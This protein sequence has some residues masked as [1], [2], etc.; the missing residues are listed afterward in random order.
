MAYVAHPDDAVGRVL[1]DDV[2]ELLRRRKPADGVDGDLEGLRSCIRRLPKLP[3]WHLDVLLL[4]GRDHV[5]GSKLPSCQAHRVH[6]DAHGVL[7]LTENLYIAYALDALERVLHVHVDVI[8]DKQI[9]V[10]AIG[11]KDAARENEV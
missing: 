6:P 1:D 7:A 8:R 10:A 4:D 5:C 11:R 2:V 3:G 9:A